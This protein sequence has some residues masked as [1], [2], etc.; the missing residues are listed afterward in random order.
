MSTDKRQ[1]ALWEQSH[2]IEDLADTLQEVALGCTFQT[3]LVLSDSAHALLKEVS[4][5][6]QSLIDEGSTVDLDSGQGHL[7]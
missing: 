2:R 7:L 3:M 4:R 1:Q 6:R 5:I